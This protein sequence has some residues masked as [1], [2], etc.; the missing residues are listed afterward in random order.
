MW[1]IY[2]IQEN[3]NYDS[4]IK[5]DY[6]SVQSKILGDLNFINETIR[7]IL[8]MLYMFFLVVLVYFSALIN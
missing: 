4:K 2:V 8:L 1:R 5:L 3:Q 6:N 7:F